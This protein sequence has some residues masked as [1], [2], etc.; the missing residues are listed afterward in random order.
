MYPLIERLVIPIFHGTLQHITGFDRYKLQ[1]PRHSFLYFRGNQL[2]MSC[3]C[4][5]CCNKL[6]EG[7]IYFRLL[8]VIDCGNCPITVERSQILKIIIEK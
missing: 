8:N 1:I 7:C 4:N 5:G 6:Y 3:H 2:G